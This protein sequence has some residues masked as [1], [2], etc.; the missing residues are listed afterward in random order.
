MAASHARV[1]TWAVTF[2]SA[3]PCR[4]A[5]AVAWPRVRFAAAFAPLSHML[6]NGFFFIHGFD[7]T[8]TLYWHPLPGPAFKRTRR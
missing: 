8:L 5:A 6:I 1:Q 3:T 4:F 2:A 7:M